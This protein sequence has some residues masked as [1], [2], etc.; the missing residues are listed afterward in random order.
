MI[1]LYRQLH[2]AALAVLEA[3]GICCELI[4]DKTPQF[5]KSDAQ[6]LCFAQARTTYLLDVLDCQKLPTAECIQC[7]ADAAE[8]YT[9]Q[10]K[11]CENMC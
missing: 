4:A 10:V 9:T 1:K 3:S 2:D 8:R 7:C 11:V 5:F 6:E